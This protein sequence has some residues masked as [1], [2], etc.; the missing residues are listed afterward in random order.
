[1]R[2]HF[3]ASPRAF[4]DEISPSAAGGL[5]TGIA[6]RPYAAPN[7]SHPNDWLERVYAGR[8]NNEWQR[9]GVQYADL[10]SSETVS[11][12]FIDRSGEHRKRQ[13]EARQE[14]RLVGR[15]LRDE[16]TSYSPR[17]ERASALPAVPE[18]H[19][20]DA[21]RAA[22]RTIHSH[23]GRHPPSLSRRGADGD[24]SVRSV[25]SSRLDSEFESAYRRHRAGGTPRV[26]RETKDERKAAA[27][28]QVWGRNQYQDPRLFKEAAPK[29][30]AGLPSRQ[31]AFAA[32]VVR[33][34]PSVMDEIIWGHDIDRSHSHPSAEN[35]SVP[36]RRAS[37]HRPV[38][39]EARVRER[40]AVPT[41]PAGIE[42]GLRGRTE[43]RRLDYALGH[44]WQPSRDRESRAW[45]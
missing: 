8:Y 27:D 11:E 3:L 7:I 34:Q 10:N 36:A 21:T 23:A 2:G 28:A 5:S 26:D 25:A 39:A 22:E 41:Y 35:V 4:K 15:G 40:T 32:G 19:L 12:R 44:G 9:R 38:I 1:M 31:H 30:S 29:T 17:R 18:L 20:Q 45:H 33:T 14:E 37:D 13:Y 43:A 6:A 16:S 42:D 24:E